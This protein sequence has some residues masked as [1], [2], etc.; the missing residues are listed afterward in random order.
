MVGKRTGFSHFETAFAHLSPDISTQVVD[1]PH[2]A[3]VGLFGEGKNPPQSRRDA[4][5]AKLCE[6]F[7]GFYRIVSHFIGYYRTEQAR[8]YAISRILS[9]GAFFDK[10]AGK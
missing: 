6:K 10:E 5:N 8:N 7:T 3:M 4:E 2:L 9:I 1:F